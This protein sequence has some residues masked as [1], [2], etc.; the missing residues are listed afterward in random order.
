MYVEA[1]NKRILILLVIISTCGVII[2]GCS[3]QEIHNTKYKNLLNTIDTHLYN[4]YEYLL[5]SCN[6]HSLDGNRKY[7]YK[8]LTE[9][10][11][12]KIYKKKEFYTKDDFIK[13]EYLTRYFDTYNYYVR[14]QNYNIANKTVDFDYRKV[15][16]H[17]QIIN[18]FH[19]S[20]FLSGSE[21]YHSGPIVGL[22]IDKNNNVIRSVL[23]S[24]ME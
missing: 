13:P 23:G 2:I 1:L 10:E 3:K 24:W 21:C 14:D 8:Y 6:I 17:I 22:I 4:N 12:I 15:G 7:I 5:D 11:Y 18:D 9:E 20:I 19:I 16:V